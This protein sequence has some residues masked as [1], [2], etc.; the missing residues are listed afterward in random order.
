MDPAQKVSKDDELLA[1]PASQGQYT[2]ITASERYDAR[3]ANGHIA[4]S[5]ISILVV[6]GL[7]DAVIFAADDSDFS[8]A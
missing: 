4:V 1:P 8:R 5:P 3:H 7:L 2:V 6:S